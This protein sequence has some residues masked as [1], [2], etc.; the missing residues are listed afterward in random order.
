[1]LLPVKKT[2]MLLPMEIGDNNKE[3]NDNDKEGTSEMSEAK[4]GP[5]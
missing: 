2:A 4:R 3:D 1:M 5:S